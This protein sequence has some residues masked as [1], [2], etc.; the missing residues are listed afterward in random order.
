ML[1]L[2]A[3]REEIGVVADQVGSPTSALDIADGIFSVG[4]KLLENPKESSLRGLFHMAGSG[5][6]SWAEFAT[7]IFAD[8]ARLGGPTAKVRPIATADYPTPAKRPSNSRL[9][10]TK[11]RDA[12]GITLPPWQKSL[13]ECVERLL[14]DAGRA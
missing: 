5:T 12:H 9:D 11:L 1:R 10:C 8:S 3:E 14:Q 2:G 7:K 13:S 4:R 6:A